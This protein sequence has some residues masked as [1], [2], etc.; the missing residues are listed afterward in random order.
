[1]NTENL[2][3]AFVEMKYMAKNLFQ[4][5]ILKRVEEFNRLLVVSPDEF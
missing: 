4:E 3:F 5:E 2:H 1:M